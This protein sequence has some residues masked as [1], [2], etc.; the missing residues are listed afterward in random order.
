MAGKGS[1]QLEAG[2]EWVSRD[3]F[4]AVKPSD[5]SSMS[6]PVC[7]DGV[8]TVRA[9]RNTYASLRLWAT[10]EGEYSLDVEVAGGVEADLFCGWYHKMAPRKGAA[11]TVPYCVDALVPVELGSTRQLPDGDNAVPGQTTQE[12]WL[13]LFVPAEADVGRASGRIV[14]TAGGETVE[15]PLAVD[16]IEAVAPDD[17]VITNDHNSYGCRWAPEMYPSVFSDDDDEM[18]RWAKIIEIVHNYYRLCYEHHG[19]LSNLGAGHAGTYDRIYGPRTEGAG[20]EKNLVDWELFDLHHG[21]LLDGSAFAK[22]GAGAPR[23]RRKPKPVWG[24]YTPI[25]AHWPADYLYWGQPGYEV[26]MKRGLGQFDQHFREKGW[27]TTRPYFFF[28]HKKRF[29]WFEWDG[30]EPKYAKDFPYWHEMGRLYKE[31]V[32]D[33][34]VPWAF[35]ADASWQMKNM[36]EAFGG[37]VDY[38]VSGGFLRW[39]P[40][41]SAKVVARGDVVWTYSGTPPIRDASAAVLEHVWQIWARGIHGHCDWLSIRPGEDPWFNCG[42]AETGTIYPGERFGIAGPIPSARLKLKRNATQDI[43]LIDAAAKAA[44]KLDQVRRRLDEMVPLRAWEKPPRAVLELPPDEWNGYNLTEGPQ[45][46][47]GTQDEAMSDH[48]GQDPLWWVPIRQA[49]LGEEVK[50]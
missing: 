41:E 14:L 2:N 45:P 37:V 24:V 35:R 36:W 18:T 13:D 28:N 31:T 12:Y 17:D 3:P 48:S 32:G 1:W 44:G 46:A 43:N 25:N 7:V 22:S 16:I 20:R 47:E 11:A 29:R 6:F 9:A 33:S 5:V 4:G 23:P 34:P 21:P 40:E 49:A 8:A 19:M 38:W 42:G 39:Y 15:L 30:D 50:R 26:E 10:G 27:L